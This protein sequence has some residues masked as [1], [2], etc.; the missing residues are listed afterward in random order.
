MS[1]RYE[2]GSPVTCSE[3]EVTIYVSQK[4]SVATMHNNRIIKLLVP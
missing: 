4:T 1:N 3:E 2:S